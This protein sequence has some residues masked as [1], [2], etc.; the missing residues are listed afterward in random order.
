MKTL[1]IGGPHD[2]TRMEVPGGMRRLYLTHRDQV[3]HYD[4]QHFLSAAEDSITLFV[5]PG[6]DAM[7]RLVEKYPEKK[8]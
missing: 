1:I 3:F 5:A 7:W 6:E 4:A 2:G 8:S